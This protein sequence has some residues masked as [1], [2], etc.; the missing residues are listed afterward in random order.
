MST[1][2]PFAAAAA[3]LARIIVCHALS[4]FLPFEIPIAQL[5]HAIGLHVPPP[6]KPGRGLNPCPIGE[7]FP[8]PFRGAVFTYPTHLAKR[9]ERMVLVAEATSSSHF[10]RGRWEDQATIIAIL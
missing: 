3:E 8:W 1:S 2:P 10:R 4:F 5:G 9:R 6:K 7:V